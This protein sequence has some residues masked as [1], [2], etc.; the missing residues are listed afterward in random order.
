MEC[1]RKENI[2]GESQTL[3]FSFVLFFFL[4]FL[5]LLS[6]T[7]RHKHTGTYMDSKREHCRLE[8]DD[9]KRP[10]SSIGHCVWTTRGEF[11]TR[12][13]GRE[14]LKT[15]Q[16]CSNAWL[17]INR[18]VQVCPYNT[19]F[20]SVYD[21]RQVRWTLLSLIDIQRGVKKCKSKQNQ[22]TKLNCNP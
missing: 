22:P 10:S 1:G 5:V 12:H 6:R 4:I 14:N 15:I 2:T 20:I 19:T 18:H 7:N 17:N 13:K 9:R 21:D 16:F 11:N 3:T 8:V